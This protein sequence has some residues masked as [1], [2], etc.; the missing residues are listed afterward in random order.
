MK[1]YNGKELMDSFGA[2]SE[3]M[4]NLQQVASGKI[5][6]DKCCGTGWITPVFEKDTNDSKKETK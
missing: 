6:C 2:L 5:P 4:K 1:V 3:S